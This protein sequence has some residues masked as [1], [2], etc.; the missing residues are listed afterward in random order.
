MDREMPLKD[1]LIEDRFLDNIKNLNLS[2]TISLLLVHHIQQ[3][4][5]KK[6]YLDI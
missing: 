5:H 2:L 1:L 4:N 3:I 6:Y